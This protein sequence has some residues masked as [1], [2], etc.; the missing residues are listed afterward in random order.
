LNRRRQRETALQALFQAE[1]ARISGEEAFARTRTVLG[2]ENKDLTFAWELVR[3][4]G[5]QQAAIDRVIARVSHDWRL[6]RITNVDRN[7]IRIALFE[8][9]F[10]PDIPA[11]VAVNEAVELAKMYGTDDSGRFVN[12]ILG[13]VVEQ[14]DAY[15]PD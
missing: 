10:R 14:P 5:E 3:G 6:E 13:K 9:L 2:L 15:W 11:N 4:V 7:I 1:L 12:G 8:L